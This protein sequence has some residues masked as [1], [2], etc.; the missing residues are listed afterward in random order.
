MKP[1]WIALGWVVTLAGAFVLGG[2]TAESTAPDPV[3]RDTAEVDRLRRKVTELEEKADAA[4]V[5]RDTGPQRREVVAA[6]AAPIPGALPEPEPV[7]SPDSAVGAFSLEGIDSPEEGSERLMAFLDAQF[8]RGEAGFPAILE[9]LGEIWQNREMV[10][11][12]FADEATA[13]RFLYPWVK[14]LV[15]HE[16]HV[17]D[18]SEHL[19]KTMAENPG[20]LARVPDD[21]VLE[22]FTE[23]VAILLPGA[24][25][26]ERLARF[27]E[28][29]RKILETPETDQPQAVR[30]NRQEIERAL[31]QFWAAPLTVEEALAK[32]RSGEVPPRELRRLL[33]L[34]PA[35]ALQGIDLT[36]LLLP[37]IS[38]G[39]NDVLRV[40][41]QLPKD[42]L[43]L[44]RL[45][46]AV[47]EAAASRS[48]H[49]WFLSSY[50]QSTGRTKWMEIRPFMDRIIGRGE[51]AAVVA[52]QALAQFLPQG[53]RP[54]KEYMADLLA[55]GAVPDGFEDI[56]RKAY[57]L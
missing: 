48:I 28:Y 43:D 33:R 34:V 1:V 7:A 40:L 8:A 39:H 21:D 12:L 31:A 54:E 18:F 45:D 4:K 19:Y 56:V 2:A 16:D 6:E 9:A 37:A 3:P 25:P 29:G 44:G 32:L 36:A 20:A 53:S 26:E 57:G 49:G 27:R 35:D 5:R 24:V 50:L 55:R 10:E 30:Q 41:Q 11:G 38:Q 23:G 51:G 15:E 52:V 46:A 17:L 14:Y 42:R 47:E 13:T 22:I